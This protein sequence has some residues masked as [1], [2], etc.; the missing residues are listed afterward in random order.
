MIIYFLKILHAMEK[1]E[2]F[3]DIAANLVLCHQIIHD[4]VHSQL[5]T[6]HSAITPLTFL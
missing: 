3:P 5:L 1:T 2:P 4:H 6:E